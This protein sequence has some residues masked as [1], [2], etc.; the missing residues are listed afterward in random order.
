MMKAETAWACERLVQDYLLRALD[1]MLGKTA[2]KALLYHTGA[3]ADPIDMVAFHANLPKVLG[4]KGTEMVERMMLKRLFSR[5]GIAFQGGTP[6]DFFGLLKRAQ[7]S[8]E[9]RRL[10]GFE[11]GGDL[12]T[13]PSGH[14]LTADA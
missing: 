1:E 11:C 5:M 6:I 13:P 4:E 3:T 9:E 14:G 12:H 2:A 8:L 7:E 10:R